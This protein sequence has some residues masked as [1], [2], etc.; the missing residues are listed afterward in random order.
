MIL[1]FV[2]IYFIILIIIE[3]IF[4]IRKVPNKQYIEY[5]K[6]DNKEIVKENLYYNT[7]DKDVEIDNYI[8][9]FYILNHYGFY[10][11]NNH[12]NILPENYLYNFIIPVKIKIIKI[13]NNIEYYSNLEIE[14]KK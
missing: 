2:L 14:K 7:T 8:G 1:L 11:N 4:I 13:N 12:W 5:K 3:F 6:I 10:I 9:Q